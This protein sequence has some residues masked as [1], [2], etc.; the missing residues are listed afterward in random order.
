[1]TVKALREKLNGIKR[2]I[3]L[4]YACYTHKGTPWYAKVSI[5]LVLAYAMSPIDLIPDFIPV[6]GCLDDILII[7][8]GITLSL[9]M[10]PKEILEQCKSELDKKDM[11]GLKKKGIY[12]ASVI[13]LIWII[14]VYYVYK[15]LS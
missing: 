6:L 9:K 13:I 4:L 10:I 14:S 8:L 2:N 11:S 1:M 15:L 12:G 5:I 7:P 3:N